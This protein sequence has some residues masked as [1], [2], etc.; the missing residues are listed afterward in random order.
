MRITLNVDD[1]GTLKASA[2]G[3]PQTTFPKLNFVL[4]TMYVAKNF[5]ENRLRVASSGII[6]V[7]S[8][9]YDITTSDTNGIANSDL[10]IYVRY[11]TNSQLGY[12]ATGVSC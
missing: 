1:F 3:E 8:Q 9:C 6:N 12:G 5:Y 10:H 2:N 4:K 7:P 11:I